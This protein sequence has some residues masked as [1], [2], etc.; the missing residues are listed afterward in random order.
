EPERR[1]ICRDQAQVQQ[2]IPPEDAFNRNQTNRHDDE[3]QSKEQLMRKQAEKGAPESPWCEFR[4]PNARRI[5]A[6]AGWMARAGGGL[7]RSD[8]RA[9]TLLT[10]AAG[11]SWS[12]LSLHKRQAA[13]FEEWF[14]ETAA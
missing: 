14:P 7:A 2:R 1:D 13:G 5:V 8:S 4:R 10:A 12:C 6:R 11:R 3:E 9:S